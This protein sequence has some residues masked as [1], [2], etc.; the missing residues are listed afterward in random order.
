VL[1]RDFF[2]ESYLFSGTPVLHLS[3]FECLLECLIAEPDDT[4]REVAN[5]RRIG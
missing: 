4:Y 3:D 1:T 5:K 2:G